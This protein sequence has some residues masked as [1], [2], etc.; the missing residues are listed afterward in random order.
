METTIA[1]ESFQTVPLV[2]LRDMD[3]YMQLEENGRDFPMPGE[4]YSFVRLDLSR[5]LIKNPARTY[6]VQLTENTMTGAGLRPGDIL[7]VDRGMEARHR[8]LI[9]AYLEGEFTLRRLLI[10][11]DNL[12]LAAEN[13]EIPPQEIDPDTTFNVWGV[14]RDVIRAG[15]T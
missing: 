3:P 14:V 7:V 6:F 13:P 2:A 5:T 8:S 12:I 11:D 10:G 1:F 15:E 9:I 4:E